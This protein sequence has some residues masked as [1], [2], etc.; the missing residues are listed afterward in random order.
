[1]S[2]KTG[3][4]GSIEPPRSKRKLPDSF[5]SAK[6]ER[7]ALTATP[8]KDASLGDVIHVRTP[9][10][11]ASSPSTRS[12][13]RDAAST[14]AQNSKELVRVHHS[15]SSFEHITAEI[16]EGFKRAKGIAEKLY[17][18]QKELH[19]AR[20]KIAR[21]DQAVAALQSDVAME[22]FKTAAALDKVD[23]AEA[24]TSR[25]R[26][27]IEASKSILREVADNCR[28]IVEADDAAQVDRTCSDANGILASDSEA[29]DE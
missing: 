28:T 4:V 24:E 19:H 8:S 14:P 5:A 29:E 2:S 13:K 17:T 9:R 20:A 12:S 22:R 21:L 25:L 11:P 16:E 6:R 26:G 23:V 7:A 27:Y 1:M 18:D 10:P 3:A 15:T